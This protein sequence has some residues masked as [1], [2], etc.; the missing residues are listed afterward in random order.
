MTL[1]RPNSPETWAAA[2]CLVEEYATSLNLDL[3]FQDF[4]HEIQSL[5]HEYGPPEGC[6]ILAAE[7]ETL[8]GCGGL[9]RFSDSAC[10]MK[11]L[12]VVPEQR[13]HGVGRKIVEALIE[14]ARHLGYTAIL[15]DSLPSMT[16]ALHLYASLEFRPTSAYRRNPVPGASFWKLDLQ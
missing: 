2:R 7:Q 6:F 1:E 9:R 4:E 10:E 14:H 13:G 16:G 5:E 15:L 3:E 11:R 8:V 12:Y